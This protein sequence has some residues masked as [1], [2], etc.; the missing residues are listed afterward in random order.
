MGAVSAKWQRKCGP[1]LWTTLQSKDP[2]IEMN[3]QDGEDDQRVLRSVW[4]P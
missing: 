1:D 2:I 4:H 3:K